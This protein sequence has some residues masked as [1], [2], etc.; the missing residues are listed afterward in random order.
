M[1]KGDVTHGHTQRTLKMQTSSK[2][3]LLR[4]LSF[5]AT[6]RYLASA[7]LTVLQTAE[8]GWVPLLTCRRR[9]NT[10]VPL[11][12]ASSVNRASVFYSPVYNLITASL[13]GARVPKDAAV[14][15]ET[16]TFSLC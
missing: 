14:C 10:P 13:Q 7:A 9:A 8:P 3:I 12:S 15:Q 16:S 2:F 11:S 5:Q 6:P 1:P 4:R